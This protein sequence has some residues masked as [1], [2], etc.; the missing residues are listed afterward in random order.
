MLDTFFIE[1]TKHQ[2][3]MFTIAIIIVAE[4]QHPN[5]RFEYTELRD[6]SAGIP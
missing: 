3:E 1:I 6:A 2:F 4:R 5:R